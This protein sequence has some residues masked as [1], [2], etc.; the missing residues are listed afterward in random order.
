MALYGC[1]FTDLQAPKK[2]RRFQFFLGLSQL[3]STS[4]T[5]GLGLIT[6]WISPKKPGSNGKDGGCTQSSPTGRVQSLLQKDA[7]CVQRFTLR[8]LGL[9]GRLKSLCGRRFGQWRVAGRSLSVL[10]R[11]LWP[12]SA[13]Q[14]WSNPSG[15]MTLSARIRTHPPTAL[16]ASP[17]LVYRSTREAA[18]FCE[19]RYYLSVRNRL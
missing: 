9:G 18:F 1:R 13:S 10:R 11:R 15:H 19:C 2:S 5:L 14:L 8:R 17:Q 7:G 3:E 4:N 12:T 16:R 6:L